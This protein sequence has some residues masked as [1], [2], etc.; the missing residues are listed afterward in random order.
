QKLAD[1][2]PAMLPHAAPARPKLELNA[3]GAPRVAQHSQTGEV[4]PAPE[5]GSAQSGVTNGN[6]ATFIALSASPAPPAPVVPPQGNLAARVSISPEGKQPGVLGGSPNGT[7]SANGG[8]VGGPA[9]MSGGN[10]TGNGSP[11]NGIDMSISGGHPPANGGNS[12]L[13]GPAK[14]STAPPRALINKPD[15]HTK[16]D[17]T[18]EQTGP[19]NFASLPA[20]AQPEQIFASKKIYKMLVN[21]PNLNSA[22]GSWIL[23]FSE[24][25]TGS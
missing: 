25:R 15:P 2:A 12:G 7:P 3:G 8:A 11:K 22:T 5:V 19:P 14:I 18:P 10:A 23:N 16:P 21:M 6:A 1:I 24:L 20:S 13:G 17:D 4:E 9:S